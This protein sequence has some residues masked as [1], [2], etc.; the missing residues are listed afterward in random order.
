MVD[1]LC[2][3]RVDAAKRAKGS[4][5]RRRQL[6]AERRVI[7][8]LLR[9]N[10]RKMTARQAAEDYGRGITTMR[11]YAD[12]LGESFKPCDPDDRPTFK[13]TRHPHEREAEAIRMARLWQ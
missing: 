4:K 1:N 5:I 6:M 7:L 3:P 13:A 11:R 10:C 2:I 9:G 12:A 8:D